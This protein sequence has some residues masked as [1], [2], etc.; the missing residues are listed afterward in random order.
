MM[1]TFGKALR[2]ARREK[3]LTLSTVAKHLGVS[4]AYV[5][6]VERGRRAPFTPDKMRLLS[7][8]FRSELPGLAKLAAASREHFQLSSGAPGTIR[9]E[10]AAALA[11][12]WDDLGDTQLTALRQLLHKGKVG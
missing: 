6:A 1:N 9:S 5:S 8:L 12:G 7:G 10:T 3:D 4:T 2:T 11:R